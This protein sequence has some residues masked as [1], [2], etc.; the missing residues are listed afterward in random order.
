MEERKHIKTY[1]IILF[2]IFIFGGFLGLQ[3]YFRG[4]TGLPQYALRNSEIKSAYEY[5]L[6][7]PELLKQIPCNCGCDRLGHKN[8]EDCF[9]KEFRDNGKVVFEEHGANCGVCYSTAL[10]SKDLFGQGKGIQEVKN[11]INEKYPKYGYGTI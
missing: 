10:D 2:L 9:I 6:K 4:K 5:A 7:N 11:F 3:H 1:I 8:V